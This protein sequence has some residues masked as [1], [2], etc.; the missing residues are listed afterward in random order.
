MDQ[1]ALV[2]VSLRGA[3]GNTSDFSFILPEEKAVSHDVPCPAPDN[4]V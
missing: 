1:P 3:H 4:P 2:S